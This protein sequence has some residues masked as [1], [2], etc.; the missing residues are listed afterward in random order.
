MKSG[1]SSRFEAR[2]ADWLEVPEALSRTLE[3]ATPLEAESVDLL[4]AEGRAL[5]ESILAE[6]TLPPW[7]NSAMDGYAVR[8]EDVA[9]ASPVHPKILPVVGVVR[10]GGD[11]G[12]RLS[13]GEAIRIMTGAPIPVGADTV[14]R[15]E[16][17][18]RE[19]EEGHVRV[20]SDRDQGR[21]VRAAGQDMRAGTT[22]F[23][24]GQA[25]TPGVVGVLAAAGRSRVQVH[26][27]PKVAVLSTGDELRTAAAY[28]DVR[29]GRGVPESNGPM[30]A[31]MLRGIG[32]DPVALGIASDD[33]DDLRTRI[34]EGRSA[35]VL[36]TI[37][38]ASMG[39][40]DLVKRV[41]ADVGFELDFWRVRMR[42]G[43]PISFG[44]LEG[45]G[46]RQA[47]FGLPGN[48]SSA[49]VTFELFVRP[50]VLRLAGHTKVRRRVVPCIAA[51]RIDTPA[52]LTYFQRVGI[53]TEGGVLT[54][55]L[56]GP[57]LSGLVTGLARADGL[58]IV[59]PSRSSVEPG[60]SIDVVLLDPGPA[61]LAEGA[62]G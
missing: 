3:A 52:D 6:A 21:H 40:A 12:M 42:P 9:G 47:V 46:H 1:P 26:R 54:A 44:W 24:A 61:A 49:F 2:E 11:A 51:E 36:V 29:A 18:D 10:A 48:P 15:V 19:E 38:G 39:E 62:A 14:I 27:R 7:D 50:Y 4:H 34:E 60:E 35:D 41:L 53:S 23:E 45:E 20:I 28:D 16:D 32:A 31:A 5:A 8:A 33:P 57:Q 43:S 22:L 25:V 17:T 55:H 58:A 30:L 56:T 13:A 59:N 37:G